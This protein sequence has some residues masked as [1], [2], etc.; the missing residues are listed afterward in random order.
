[1]PTRPKRRRCR[2][3]QGVLRKGLV[4]AIHPHCVAL[5]RVGGQGRISMK[6]VARRFKKNTGMSL[7]SYVFG[8][9]F[10]KGISS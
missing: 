7:V 1:M 6:W 4:A 10:S 5:E 9:E 8:K 3:C 2:F